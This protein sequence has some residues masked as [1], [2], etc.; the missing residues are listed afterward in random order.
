MKI[1]GPHYIIN[2]VMNVEIKYS[3][4]KDKSLMSP[5]ICRFSFKIT[6]LSKYLMQ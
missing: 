3:L 5:N 6:Y 1:G 4:S 2:H